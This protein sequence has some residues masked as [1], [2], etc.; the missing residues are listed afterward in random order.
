MSNS[1]QIAL[2]Q[3]SLS[4]EDPLGN[5]NHIEN[6]IKTLSRSVDL[7][8]LPEMFSTGFSMNPTKVEKEE[9]PKTK[10]WMM[11]MARVYTVALVG[12]ISFYE[13][14]QWYNRCFF[15]T[16]EGLIYQ[17]DKRHTFSL[18]GEN[19]T[20]SSGKS[21]VVVPY[22]GFQFLLQ[23]CYDLRFPV[24]ARN[25]EDYDAVLY[26]ANWPKPRIAAWD[27]LLKARAIENMAYAIGVN[28]IGTDPNDNEYPGH[29]SVYDALGKQLVFSEESEV[30]YTTLEK[31]HL[32]QTRTNLGFLNDRDRFSLKV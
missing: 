8:V 3:T 32:E 1:I 10:A 13:D 23:I 27:T 14:G 21:R 26:V 28:R 4:W 19:K 5:R 11:T 7:L 17:Y 9:G 24:W 2:L 15:V 16:P 29:S 12:S 20:Y 31:K 30:L 22:K 6:K 18:A 25:T